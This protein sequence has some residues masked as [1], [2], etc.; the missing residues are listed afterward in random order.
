MSHGVC[1]SHVCV[2][3]CA[4]IYTTALP[5]LLFLLL[6]LLLSAASTTTRLEN[7]AVGPNYI[8]NRIMIV[9]HARLTLQLCC[10]G[11]IRFFKSCM[12]RLLRPWQDSKSH[13]VTSEQHF[14]T[15][16][17]VHRICECVDM[18]RTRAGCS[19]HDASHKQ[20]EPLTLQAARKTN[21]LHALYL[22]NPLH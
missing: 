7:P 10:R 5:L 8:H 1:V 2:C 3:V 22:T 18:W 19:C 21:L 11:P 4:R 17:H 6:V 9:T 13:A 20:H 15:E 16:N 12:G 14:N